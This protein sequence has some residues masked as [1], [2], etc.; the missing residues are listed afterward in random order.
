MSVPVSTANCDRSW[1]AVLL[2][3]KFRWRTLIIFCERWLWRADVYRC[4]S[5]RAW[6]ML[7]VFIFFT[8]SCTAGTTGWYI[9]RRGLV[10]SAA[11]FVVRL[12][13]VWASTHHCQ[14]AKSYWPA[15]ITPRDNEVI[16][17]IGCTVGRKENGLV[18]L[19]SPD[20]AGCTGQTP[21]RNISSTGS[22]EASY[23]CT[24]RSD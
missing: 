24:S 20:V 9:T 15:F 19:L 8:T 13:T 4:G 22:R 10:I 2:R 21:V 7:W 14:A 18:T 17:W 11:T 12:S 16:E 23:E 1:P 6:V 3:C 5:S